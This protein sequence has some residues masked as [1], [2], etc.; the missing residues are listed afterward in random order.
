MT[1]LR[2]EVDIPRL[3]HNAPKGEIVFAAL[4]LRRARKN[5]DGRDVVEVPLKGYRDQPTLA[6]VDFGYC[7]RFPR[8]TRV[9]G[10]L[11]RKV[12]R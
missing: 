2:L 12:I 3:E 1:T 8:V 10:P 4:L 11:K 6:R 5:L 9:V 7:E